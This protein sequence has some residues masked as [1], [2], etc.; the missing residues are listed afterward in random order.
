[1]KCLGHAGKNS[2][3]DLASSCDKE[4]EFTDASLRRVEGCYRI[5]C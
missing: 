1:M 4:D 2:I 5:V 3:N